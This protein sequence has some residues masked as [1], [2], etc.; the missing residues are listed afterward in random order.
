MSRLTFTCDKLG[1]IKQQFCLSRRI[2]LLHLACI[3]MSD[4]D[5]VRTLIRPNHQP[6]YGIC[7]SA[8]L[9]GDKRV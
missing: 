1:A 9:A 3:I 7:A 6:S 8:E 4:V 2:R 5:T